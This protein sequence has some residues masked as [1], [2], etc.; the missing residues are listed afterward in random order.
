MKSTRHSI[1]TRLRASVAV[2]LW[3]L[4]LAA[5]AAPY[6]PTEPNEVLLVIDSAQRQARVSLNSLADRADPQA[7]V[8]TASKFVALGRAQH[9]E[10]YFGY[11]SA[12]LQPWRDDP[13]APIPI[14]LL[15]ADVAQYQHR[16]GDALQIL[17]GLLAR[18]R[19]SSAAWLMRATIRLSQ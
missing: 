5:W 13:D 11:A 10:R 18:D 12:T 14:L 2:L 17:D 19:S 1:S 6:K 16:F 9:D 15:R 7:A 8:A 3:G 4:A